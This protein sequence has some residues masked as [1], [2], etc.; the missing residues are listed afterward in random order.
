MAE[1]IVGLKVKVG[2]DEAEKSVKSLRAQLKEAQADVA[3]MS[4]KFGVTSKEAAQAAKRAAELKDAIGDAKSLTDAFNPDAK[5]KAFSAS[6][7]GVAAGFSAVQGSMALLGSESEDVQKALL[8][9]QAAMALSQ[10]LQAVGESIDSFKQLGAVVQNSTAFIKL[11][12]IANKATAASMRLFGISVEATSTSFKVLKG[13]IAATGIGL[14]VVALGEAI[15]YL[16][17]YSSAAE[18]AAKAQDDLNKKTLEYAEAG[19][20]GSIDYIDKNTRLLVAQAKAKGASEKE[21]FDIE[22]SGRRL[23]A[24]SLKRYYGEVKEA[25]SKAAKDAKDEI[26]K[27]NIDGLIAQAQFQESERKQAEA[28]EEKRKEAARKKAEDHKR[29]LEEEMQRIEAR[30]KFEYD[31]FKMRISAIDALNKQNEE[32]RKEQDAK[33]REI[34]NESARQAELEDAI[35]ESRSKEKVRQMLEDSKLSVSIAQ[36]EKDAKIAAIDATASALTNL[37]LIAGQQTVFGKALAISA[38]IINT[39][40]GATK[41]LAQGG[42]LGIAT[43]STVIASG[44]LA[45]K[46]IISTKVPTPQGGGSTGGSAPSISTSAPLQP[47]TEIQG[48]RVE[49]DQRS[50]NALGNRAIRAYVVERDITG[51]QSKISR[52]ER[53]TTFG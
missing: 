30:N 5:F 3:A 18:D 28:A 53:Q 24:E 49:L 47:A 41:A 44:L 31:N 7:S 1:E 33:D 29:E 27:N 16:Q 12:E 21:I 43:A 39:Y 32:S 23:R 22:Q 46:N 37:S 38:A 20:K 15:S 36:K 6:I 2:S 50:I 19:L 8:K 42:F 48:Q 17:N 10:G 45:V 51:A 25:D 14:L 52:I 4:E 11:N 13:A 34:L 35:N 40:Q 26:E 9:V